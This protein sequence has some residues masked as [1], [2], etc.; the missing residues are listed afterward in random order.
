MV[1]GD[2]IRRRF[3][4]GPNSC[5]DEKGGGVE[6]GEEQALETVNEDSRHQGNA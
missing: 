2:D 5:S 1:V 4:D 3:Q 6:G